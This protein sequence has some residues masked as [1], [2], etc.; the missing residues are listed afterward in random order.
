MRDG[1]STREGL[2]ACPCCGSK[3]VEYTFLERKGNRQI[4]PSFVICN[5][6]GLSAGA[7]DTYPKHPV[8]VWNTRLNA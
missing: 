6:C 1:E 3:D 2:L 8:E 4:G 5:G 7:E